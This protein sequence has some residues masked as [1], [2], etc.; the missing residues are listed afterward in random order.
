MTIVLGQAIAEVVVHWCNLS[1]KRSSAGITPRMSG[2]VRIVGRQDLGVLRKCLKIV[3]YPKMGPDLSGV[4]GLGVPF[5]QLTSVATK[6][7]H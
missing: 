1:A 6:A 7:R 5:L 4:P 2:G 3:K